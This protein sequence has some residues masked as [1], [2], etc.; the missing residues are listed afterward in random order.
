[1]ISA[2]L[3]APSSTTASKSE[4]WSNLT[5][6]SSK[7]GRGPT[8]PQHSLVIRPGSLR[9]GKHC[10][11]GLELHLSGLNLLLRLILLLNELLDHILCNRPFRRCS[12][13]TTT[14]PSCE[15]CPSIYSNNLQASSYIGCI[16]CANSIMLPWMEIICCC[17]TRVLVIFSFCRLQ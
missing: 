1:M 4:K 8:C 17:T 2:P 16:F 10:F 5:K 11:E 15:P 9:S 13:V 6:I 12:S 14:W 3:G 7:L